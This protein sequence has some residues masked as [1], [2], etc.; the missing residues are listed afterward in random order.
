VNAG[1]STS[2]GV[3]VLLISRSAGMYRVDQA[4]HGLKIV[5]AQVAQFGIQLRERN[6]ASV[7]L[8]GFTRQVGPK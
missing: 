5:N 8:R 6:G 1:G 2:G 7:V 3:V 4:D